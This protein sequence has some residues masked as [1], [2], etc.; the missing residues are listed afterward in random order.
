VRFVLGCE[1]EDRGEPVPTAYPP[2]EHYILAP[3]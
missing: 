1:A 3:A 2:I